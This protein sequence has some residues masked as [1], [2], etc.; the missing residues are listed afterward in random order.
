MSLLEAVEA[1]TGATLALDDDRPVWC[2]AETV[3]IDEWIIVAPTGGAFTLHPDAPVV[4]QTIVDGQ[5]IGWVGDQPVIVADSGTVAGWL[6]V[7]GERVRPS[8]PLLWLRPAP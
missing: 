1:T 8:Q 3:T 7:S 4:G 2:V 5:P 6:A